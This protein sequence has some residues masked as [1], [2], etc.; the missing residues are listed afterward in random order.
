MALGGREQETVETRFAD[1]TGLWSVSAAVAK[2]A[3][4]CLSQLCEM[5]KVWQDTS[6]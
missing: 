1:L 4:A 2:R 3:A 6:V 5:L